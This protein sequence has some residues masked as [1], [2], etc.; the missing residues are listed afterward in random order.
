MFQGVCGLLEVVADVAYAGAEVVNS[1]VQF[2]GSLAG[3]AERHFYI[4]VPEKIPG[5][6]LDVF[7]GDRQWSIGAA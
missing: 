7:K 1:A 5:D 2:L 6:L 3:V 4:L